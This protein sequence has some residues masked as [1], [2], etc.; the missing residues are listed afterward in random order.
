MKSCMVFLVAALVAGA[1]AVSQA[2]DKPKPPPPK[3]KAYLGAQKCAKC[4]DAV[5]KG[6]QQGAWQ[7]SKHAGAWNTLASPAALAIGKQKGIANPQTSGECLKCHTTAFG[8]PPARL[9]AGFDP[10]LGVQCESCHGPAEGHPEKRLD[11]EDALDDD[12][13]IAAPKAEVCQRCHNKDSPSFKPFCFSHFAEKIRH[14]DPRKKRTEKE[15]EAMKCQ[16]GCGVEHE[17]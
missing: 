3:P 15:R 4:H 16:G 5:G 1:F 12:E 14:L 13:I 7:A 2:E 9:L 8:E 10:K 6:N 17:K 11:D